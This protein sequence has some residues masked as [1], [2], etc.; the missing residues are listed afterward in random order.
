MKRLQHLETMLETRVPK[1]FVIA[2]PRRVGDSMDI[3]RDTEKL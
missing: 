3:G 2:N 1:L